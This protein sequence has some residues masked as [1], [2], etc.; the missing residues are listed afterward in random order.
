VARHQ[1]LVLRK[2]GDRLVVYPRQAEWKN[3]LRAL[4]TPLEL[5]LAAGARR[6]LSWLTRVS[7]SAARHVETARHSWRVAEAMAAEDG[8]RFVVDSSKSAV[9]LKLLWALRPRQVRVVQLVRDGRAVAASAMRRKGLSADVAARIWKREN[10]HLAL[11]L[12]DVPDEQ[13]HRVRYE[14]LCAEPARE[15]ASLCGFLGVAFEAGML[16]PWEREIHNIPGN[17]M[18]LASSQRVI[19]ADERWRRE[20]PVTDVGAID[21]VA[22]SMNRSFG[23]T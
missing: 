7:P 14:D 8:T 5:A 1:V 4:P 22:G 2:E 23:Y 9:R 10:Q 6:T 16:H 13:R 11:M 21:R 12:R 17:P 20:L 3:P 19:S 18:L 15:V